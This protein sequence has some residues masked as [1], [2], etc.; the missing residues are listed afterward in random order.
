MGQTV[1]NYFQTPLLSFSPPQTGAAV[2]KTG[3]L[4]PVK[5]ADQESLDAKGDSNPLTSLYAS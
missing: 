3:A 4:Y 2:Q 5:G 1:S